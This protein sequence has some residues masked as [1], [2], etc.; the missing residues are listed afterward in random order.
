[1]EHKGLR[2]FCFQSVT[3]PATEH[4]RR[5][6]SQ[7]LSCN[8]SVFLIAAPTVGR[9]RLAIC[10][11]HHLGRFEQPTILDSMD[12]S[13]PAKNS[14]RL[15]NRGHRALR[16]SGLWNAGFERGSQRTH[17]SGSFGYSGALLA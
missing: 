11:A 15:Q 5:G 4:R 2:V 13:S 14:T 17:P 3:Q 9:F 8:A 6:T 10:D 1:V 16:D 7:H 12:C